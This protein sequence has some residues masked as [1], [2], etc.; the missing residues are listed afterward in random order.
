VTSE[1]YSCV[2]IIKIKNHYIKN[3]LLNIF[4]IVKIIFFK[5]LIKILNIIK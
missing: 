5:F 3:V 2:I 1:T 4:K